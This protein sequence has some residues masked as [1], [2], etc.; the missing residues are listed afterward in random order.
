VLDYLGRYTH[1][2]AIGNHRIKNIADG[3]VTFTA[4]NRKKDKTYRVTLDAEEFIRRFTLHIL[5]PGF[6][7]IRCFGFLA[8]A[9]KK[10]ALKTIRASLGMPPPPEP[11]EDEPKETPAEKILRLTGLDIARCP[12]CRTKLVACPLPLPQRP[13]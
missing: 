12:K 11:R 3:Q 9:S 6:Q 4:K 2:V 13:P 5:P 7:K 8:N 10:A 1:R